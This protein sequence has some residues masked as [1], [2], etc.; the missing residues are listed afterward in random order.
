MAN[1]LKSLVK[2]GFGLGLDLFLAQILFLLLGMIFFLP[3][4]N[5]YKQGSMKENASDT[6]QMTGILLMVLGVVLM[7]GAGF[8]LL[9]ESAGDL[10][11]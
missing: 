4:Y 10:F 6:T 9:M 3:G 1:S 11:N 2:T 7:G 5:L 8:G